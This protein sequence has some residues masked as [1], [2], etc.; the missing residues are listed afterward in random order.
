MKYFFK[1]IDIMITVGG[2][3][4]FEAL[5]RNI[6]CIC[7]PINYY[8]KMS[9][10]YLRKNKISNVFNYD[11][12][13][14][15]NGKKLLINCLKRISKKNIFLRKKKYLD[16]QGSKRIADYISSLKP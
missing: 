15:K 7:I 6:E 14:N 4:L 11:E 1:K 9:C 3:T 13:F 2:V 10:D 12:I 8:Q 16:D 5:C